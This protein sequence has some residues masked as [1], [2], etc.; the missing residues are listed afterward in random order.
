MNNQKH[1]MPALISLF[2]PGLG[3][4]IKGD[5]FK[6]IMI[7]VFGGLTAVFLMWTI[8]VPLIIYVWN[9]YDA[10]NSN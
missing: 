7:W 10:Y 8:I 4:M 5:F 6:G 3:Q 2:I 9:V 1:G